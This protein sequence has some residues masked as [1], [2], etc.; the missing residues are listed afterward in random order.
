VHD[1]WL[2]TRHPD[3]ST[4]RTLPDHARR[5]QVGATVVLVVGA[6]GIVALTSSAT[7]PPDERPIAEALF[8]ADTDLVLLPAHT[9]ATDEQEVSVLD[10]GGWVWSVATRGESGGC[11]LFAFED[12]EVVHRGRATDATGGCTGE[13]AAAQLGDSSP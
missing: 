11:Y 8:G 12:G 13:A 4:P 5:L 2:A 7:S 1:E 3:G 10:H 6:V 9:P